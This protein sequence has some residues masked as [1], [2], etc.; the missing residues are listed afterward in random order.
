MLSWILGLFLV[1]VCA[2]VPLILAVGV[3]WLLLR[4]RSYLDEDDISAALL[5]WMGIG[6]LIFAALFAISQASSWHGQGMLGMVFL[7]PMAGLGAVL[8]VFTAVI[9]LLVKGKAF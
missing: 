1:T 6:A 2:F 8:G 7:P 5:V 9:I 3:R 4:W